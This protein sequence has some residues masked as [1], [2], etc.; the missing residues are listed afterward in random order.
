MLWCVVDQPSFPT[1]NRFLWGIVCPARSYIG[2]L[3]RH[4]KILKVNA[5]YY[6]VDTA[7]CMSV[8]HLSVPYMSIPAAAA[9]VLCVMPPC[10]LM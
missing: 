6:A 2:G 8:S 1:L 4:E 5:E 7:F 9:G 10:G 3:G